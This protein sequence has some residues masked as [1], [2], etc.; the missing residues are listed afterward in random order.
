MQPEADFLV[1]V[2]FVLN[3]RFVHNLRTRVAKSSLCYNYF[4]LF[5][6]FQVIRE[7]KNNLFMRSKTD[8]GEINYTEAPTEP[9]D[10]YVKMWSP[11]PVQVL[12]TIVLLPTSLKLLLSNKYWFNTAKFGT[13]GQRHLL[14][15]KYK[16][17]YD[18]WSQVTF[19]SVGTT[20][21]QWIIRVVLL[22]VATFFWH[23]YFWKILN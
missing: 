18:H 11:Q 17:S 16:F 8:K 12:G 6:K 9:L 10:S 21:G 5:T 20:R 22:V 13:I 7:S 23:S 14:T 1:P 2:K 3:L 15:W 19:I 4:N